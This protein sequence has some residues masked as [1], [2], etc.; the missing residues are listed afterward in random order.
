MYGVRIRSLVD[1][2]LQN[3]E[4]Y[5]RSS[6]NSIRGKNNECF[7][8]EKYRFFFQIFFYFFYF[9]EITLVRDDFLKRIFLCLF[10]Y[11]IAL[12]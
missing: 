7:E 9:S 5:K 2:P 8:T 1:N 3:Q 12:E 10:V 11:F 4:I 6:K